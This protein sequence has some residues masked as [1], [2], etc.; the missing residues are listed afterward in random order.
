MPGALQSPVTSGS[1]KHF[2]KVGRKVKGEVA[3]MEKEDPELTSSKQTYQNWNYLQSN[4][5]QEQPEN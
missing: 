5:L 2:R 1:K 3:K 4:Y